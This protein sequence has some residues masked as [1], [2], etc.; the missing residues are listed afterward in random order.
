MQAELDGAVS[1]DGAE[2]AAEIVQFSDAF[3]IPV[4]TLTKVSG[5]TASKNDE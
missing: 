1:A 2:K 5:F 4:L 3:N